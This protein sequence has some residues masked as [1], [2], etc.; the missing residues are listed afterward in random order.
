[1]L[2]GKVKGNI[3]RDFERLDDEFPLRDEFPLHQVR[4]EGHPGVGFATNAKGIVVDS[5]FS[6][7]NEDRTDSSA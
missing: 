1:M 7:N 3:T 2:S 4:I 6:L 5:K